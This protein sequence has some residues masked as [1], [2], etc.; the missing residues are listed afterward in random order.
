M[1]NNVK[2]GQ[3][4]WKLVVN[5]NPWLINTFQLNISTSLATLRRSGVKWLPSFELTKLTGKKYFHNFL[6]LRLFVVSRELYIP[7]TTKKY[8]KSCKFWKNIVRFLAHFF[9]LCILASSSILHWHQKIIFFAISKMT[10]K[11]WIAANFFLQKFV[12]T[13][14]KTE[15]LSHFLAW[16]RSWLLHWTEFTLFTKLPWVWISAL[17]CFVEVFFERH[18]LVCS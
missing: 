16:W 8:S 4:R 9:P 7:W 10:K 11:F 14:I 3:I 1:S 18:C 5:Y 17:P 2:Q 13:E 15:L 6:V 12:F